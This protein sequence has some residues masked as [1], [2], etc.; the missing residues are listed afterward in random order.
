VRFVQYDYAETTEA[1]SPSEMD[2]RWDAHWHGREGLKED[3]S[4]EPAWPT[5]RDALT[6]R[7]R[8]LEAGCGTGQWVQFLRRSGHDAVG[9]DYA[10]AGL[11]VGRAHDPT[12]NLVQADFRA[13]P[14]DSESF[15][16]IVSFGAIEHDVTGPEA[17]LREFWRVLK[18]HGKLMCSVPCLNVYR[19]LGYPWLVLGRWLKCREVLRRLWGK[20]IPFV[21]YQ[22]VW[23]PR[24]YKA[25][26]GRCGF[27]VVDL[28][29]YGTVLKSGLTQAP[30]AV[31]R[32]F[33]PL[34]SAHM[35]MA[36]CI[37]RPGE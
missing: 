11:E 20:K 19:A 32:R 36:T 18:P 31:I 23:S 27:Q 37:K 16:Y 28:R 15:D 25:I 3:L 24:E 22:Y 12:L 29:G 10:R 9:V 35:M 21:F 13:L 30:D 1:S 8:L 4:A 14:F 26:L 2:E 6:V 7:G 34:S 5:I 33:N 17:A